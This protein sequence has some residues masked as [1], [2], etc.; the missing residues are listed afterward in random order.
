VVLIERVRAQLGFL[1]HHP[2]AI[3]VAAE[4]ERVILSGHILAEDVGRLLAGVS[5]VRGVKGVAN[6]AG[7]VRFQPTPDG[8]TRLDVKLSSNPP[9]GALG[10]LVAALFGADPKHAPGEDL[11]RLKSLLEHGR[12]SA[13]GARSRARRLP[14]ACH[15]RPFRRTL[16]GRPAPRRLGATQRASSE[17]GVEGGC[18]WLAQIIHRPAARTLGGRQAGRDQES[19]PGPFLEFT[20][21]AV[22]VNNPG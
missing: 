2:G 19:R 20:R 11:V 22:P 16:G 6:H 21:L 12:T 18:R 10:H 5:K 4:N 3:E 1:V 17:R 15:P 13:K 9:G 7:V 8:G 14:L